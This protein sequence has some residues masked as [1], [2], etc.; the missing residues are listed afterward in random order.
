L[1]LIFI[2]VASGA[3]SDSP[4]L[5]RRERREKTRNQASEAQALKADGIDSIS[6]T[7]ESAAL[8]NYELRKKKMGGI[9]IKREKSL[10]SVLFPG[11]SPEE[12]DTNEALPMYVD[13]VDS[14]K[15]PVPF[16][17]YDL[18]TCPQP[19]KQK[20]K[21]FRNSL[22]NRLQGHTMIPSPFQI[23]VRQDKG[24]TPLCSVSFGG[25]QLKWMR[26]LVDRQY[27][28]HLAL[29]QLPVLMRSK[30]LNYAVRG[31]PVG[32]KAPPSYT[33]LSTDEF[34][35]YNHLIFTISY[36]EDQDQFV[37]TRIVGFDVHPVSYKHELPEG[38]EFRAG[39]VNTMSDVESCNPLEVDGP[40]N[41]PSTYL[42]LHAGPTGED[43]EVIYSYEVNWESADIEWSDRWDVYLVGSPDDD[44][45]Y[46]AIV[47]SLMIVLFLMG[48]VATIMIRTLRKD[49]AGYNELTS[50][51]SS[52]EETGWKLIHG[53]VFRPPSSNPM[54]LSIL[55]GTG[56]QI[57]VSFLLALIAC[58]L[59]LLNPMKKG[60]TLTCI[61]MLYVLC[62]SVAGY[63]SSRLYKF[64]DAQDWKK[65]TILTATAFPGLLFSLFMVLNFFLGIVGAATHVSSV[66]ILLMF[67]LWVC[68]STPLVFIGSY[69]GFKAPKIEV[70]CKTNQIARIVPE[71]P[72]YTQHPYSGLLGGML[73]FGS[74]CIE[75]FFIMGALWL[76]QYYYVMSFLVAVMLILVSTC[77]TVSVVMTYLQYCCENHRWWWSS[78]LNCAMAGLYLF[79]YSLWFLSTK[80][81]LVGFLPVIVYLTYMSMISIAFSLVCGSVGFYS[82]FWF[83][84]TIY[85]AVKV[86]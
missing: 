83:T 65:C 60:Q 22:G 75:L 69:Y 84:K 45:H 24:C 80:M 73:P 47:N 41:H 66:T 54:L 23:D 55:V 46:F 56:S 19:A 74:V 72:F 85:S 51:E 71:Q 42:P 58:V 35:L 61:I 48:A 15:T 78:F 82:S 37:G 18:P 39:Q 26:Q 68:L 49:I 10:A 50:L 31:Y 70:P 3:G 43:V 67:L 64:C 53:D 59:K 6:N 57:G 33:G 34:F 8:R 20:V 86:D 11:V 79:I 44:I 21:G 14:R 28:I 5:S 25:K 9:L 27:R 77:A 52:Q 16:K 36:H 13:Q 63:C 38:T 32:F 40:V 29:D 2:G 76:H 7:P 30:E 12:Y 62:G 1:T 81:S 4:R 17:F